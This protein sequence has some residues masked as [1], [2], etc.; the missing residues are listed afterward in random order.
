MLDRRLVIGY[1]A[2]LAIF[3]RIRC[4]MKIEHKNRVFVSIALLIGVLSLSLSG[5]CCSRTESTVQAE[6]ELSNTEQ[7]FKVKED[8]PK[9]GEKARVTFIELGSERCI[10]CIKMQ[11]VMKE[12]VFQRCLKIKD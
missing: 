1:I 4:G 7:P 3:I 2:K 5:L 11:V 10:P 12:G 9:S 8:V 6:D